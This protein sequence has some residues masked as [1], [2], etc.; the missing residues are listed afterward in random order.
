MESQLR[1][2]RGRL[3]Q[4]LRHSDHYQL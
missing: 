4:Q 2:K 1:W 3:F